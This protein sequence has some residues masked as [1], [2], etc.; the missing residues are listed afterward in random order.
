MPDL[1]DMLEGFEEPTYQETEKKGAPKVDAADLAGLL[2]DEPAVWTGNDQK[3]GA[4]VLDTQNLLDEPE[5]TWQG[6]TP[7]APDHSVLNAAADLLGEEPAA[8][9]PVEEFCQKLQFDENLKQAF[10][11]LDA[12]KQMQVVKMRA[13]A[14]GIPAPMIPNE[15]RP[16]SPAP[17]EEASAGDETMLEEAPETEEYV[18]QFKDE[19][20]ERAKREAAQPRKD[21][22]P[23]MDLSEEEKQAN[24]RRMAQERE[25][26]E[27]EQAR[28][29][30]KTLIV[31]TVV[32]IIGAVAFCLFFSNLFGLGNKLIE[33]GEGGL[34][35]KLKG[36]AGYV[37]AAFGIGSLLLAAPVPALKGLCKFIDIV[38]FVMLLFP[39]VPLLMQTEGGGAVLGLLYAVAIL[40]CGYSAVSLIT[41]E[42]IEKYNKY[43]NV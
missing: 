27:R 8:Y 42:N 12:E 38:A 3:R 19:D 30:F 10:V 1:D 6:Q 28:K 13:D 5:Q 15:M 29:G 4:P 32:G 7:S 18:P 2:D 16:K 36:I 40:T 23:Q 22:L 21:P 11:N 35:V 33:S 37:G 20:L 25:E 26:R 9:D 39:G 24:R 43:G 14:L 41:N 17:T 31:L 34:V